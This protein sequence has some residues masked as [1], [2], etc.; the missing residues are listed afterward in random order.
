MSTP[1][2]EGEAAMKSWME[3]RK[4]EVAK[5]FTPEIERAITTPHEHEH[6]EHNKPIWLVWK[7]VRNLASGVAMFPELET[8]C[9][10]EE[11]CRYHV[12]MVSE[13]G[14]YNR[15]EEIEVH[16]ERIPANHRF[17][18]SLDTF[19]HRAHMEQWKAREK[20]KSRRELDGD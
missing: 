17:A 6:P 18:S 12:V 1:D 16:V 8:V 19:Q 2:R 5:Y 13:E 4:E 14:T 15:F 3:R 20:F 10:N 11:S 7:L 9:D